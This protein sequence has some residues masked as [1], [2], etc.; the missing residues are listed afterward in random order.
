MLLGAALLAGG[1]AA[2]FPMVWMVA[3]SFMRTGEASTYP[4]HLLP[5]APTLEHYRALFTRL[6]V[7]RYALNS[8]LVAALVTGLSLFVNAAAGYA[9]AKL[10]FRGRDRLFRLLGTALVV[11]TQ[12][13]MLPLFLLLKALH[14]VNTYAGVVVPAVAS[15]FCIFL[16]RQYALSIPDDL[17]DAAR[18]DGASEWRV[19]RSVVLPALRPALATMSIWTFLATWNDFL[20]PLIV[21][22]DDRRSTLPVALAGLLGEHAQDAELMMAGSVLTVLPVLAVFLALQRYY[23]EG[24]TAGSVK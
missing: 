18:V 15:I 16:V 4:P 2:V 14:L 8:L 10:R 7:G 20:W 3:A 24:V 22:T 6:D 17:L 21:L 5:R 23:L 1:A 12:V 13:A 11:P 19:F 9:F